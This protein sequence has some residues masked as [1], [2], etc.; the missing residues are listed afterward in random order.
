M[1]PKTEIGPI[2]RQYIQDNFIF[3]S[4]S[5][6]LLETDSLMERGLLDSMGVLEMVTFLE[7]RFAIRIPDDEVLPQN[8]DS[9]GRLTDFVCNK[10]SRAAGTIP[11]GACAS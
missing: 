1:S 10:L 8:L 5:P 6:A 2:I 9:I 7:T 4:G 3:R 11:E